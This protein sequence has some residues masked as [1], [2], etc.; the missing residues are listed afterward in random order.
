ME[1]QVYTIKTVSESGK[2]VYLST[3]LFHYSVVNSMQ[4]F[5]MQ[6]RI[7][8]IKPRTNTAAPS[9]HR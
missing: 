3:D 9:I 5:G 4:K 2:A 1:R 7:I 8:I 6:H